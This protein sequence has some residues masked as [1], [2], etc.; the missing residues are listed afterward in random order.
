M[1]EPRSA[2]MRV[3]SDASFQK[4]SIRGME[5]ASRD[6]EAAGPYGQLDDA[7][8]IADKKSLSDMH[9]GPTMVDLTDHGHVPGQGSWVSGVGDALMMDCGMSGKKH[10]LA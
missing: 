6:A 1:A 10:L 4:L 9:M 3:K 7:V 8:F 5:I 2:S